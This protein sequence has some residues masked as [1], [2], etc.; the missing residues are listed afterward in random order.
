[1]IIDSHVHAGYSEALLHSWDTFE[2]IETSIKRMDQ[3]G[4]D[5]AVI[6]PIGSGNYDLHNRQTAEIVARHPR[7]LLGYAKLSQ[8]QDAGRVEPL[9]R[10]AFE[11]LELVGLKLHGHPNREIMDVMARYKKPVLADVA[12]QVYPLRYVAEQY[13]SV[14]IIIAHM[15]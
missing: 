13:P 12:G 6:L 2:D 14:P 9:L 11:K 1:M 10:E 3:H 7:R 15:G 8:Q 5:K 4:I